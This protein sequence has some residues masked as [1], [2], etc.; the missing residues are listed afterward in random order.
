[1]WCL[2][3][4]YC[5]VRE[6][7]VFIFRS[8]TVLLAKDVEVIV[9]LSVR[10]KH[11]MDLCVIIPITPQ[12]HKL[13]IKFSSRYMFSQW[14]NTP[15]FLA[16]G[17]FIDQQS[18]V[19]AMWI[20]ILWPERFFFSWSALSMPVCQPDITLAQATVFHVP[21]SCWQSLV[22]HHL[23]HYCDIIMNAMTSQ[24]ASLIIVYSTVHSGPDQRKH[25]SSAS[26][27]FVWGI[28]RW[29]VNSPHKWPVM[30]KMFPFD[31]AIMVLNAVSTPYSTLLHSRKVRL[32]NHQYNRFRGS[33]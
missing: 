2:N 3:T 29:P 30:R 23:V 16:L 10:P 14:I 31:D 8:K 28:H 20:F 18:Q 13:F 5:G 27:A 19:M 9:W 25:Q 6:E 32:N 15:N 33:W 24:I 21:N 17:I 4:P 26:L 12:T 11:E 22:L 1:M 7:I